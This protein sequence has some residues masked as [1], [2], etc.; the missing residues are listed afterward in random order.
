MKYLRVPNW[1]EYQHYKDRNPPWIKLHNQL[2]DNFEFTTMPDES[3]AHL[4]AIWMLASRT[5]N[6]IPH[7]AQWI[8]A[9]ICAS[10]KLNIA[11]L[12]ERGF[13]E[14]VPENSGV[15]EEERKCS[16]SLAGCKQDA[17]LETEA[18][19]ETDISANAPNFALFWAEYPLKKDRARAEQKFKK[20]TPEEKSLAIDDVRRRKNLDPQWIKDNG[21]FIPHA[22]TY[23]HGKNWNDEW[24]ADLRLAA[25]SDLGD[26]V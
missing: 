3:K 26:I 20:L 7:D 11:L 2:L 8:S 19:T 10:A 1:D 12:V 6:K 14:E 5:N 18:E 25:G 17:C 23:L 21:Q 15:Q 13:L 24:R 16:N 22:K 4:L 9:K